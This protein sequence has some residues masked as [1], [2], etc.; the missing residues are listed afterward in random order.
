[1]HVFTYGTL[2]YPEVWNAVVGGAFASAKGAAQGYAIFRVRDAVFPGI[3]PAGK[4]DQV[5][6]V[7]YLDVD[8]VAVAR[9]DRFEDDFYRRESV[10]VEC[11]DGVG[12]SA[13]AYVV[14]P[15]NRSVLTSEVWRAEEFVASG[16]LDHFIRR[17][18]GF[19]RV[20]DEPPA[21]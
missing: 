14:P 10:W 21:K 5:R 6:G 4:S 18:Q 9:L 1:M 19:A 12:R 11:E 15:E 2:M 3:T 7:V 8:P 16:G 13:D 20:A 17:F